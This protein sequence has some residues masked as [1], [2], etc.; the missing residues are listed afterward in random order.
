MMEWAGCRASLDWWAMHKN[1]V[2]EKYKR[3]NLE[4]HLHLGDKIIL[5][6]I[7]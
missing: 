1:I 2:V 4:V 5:N 7:L 3:K 6:L